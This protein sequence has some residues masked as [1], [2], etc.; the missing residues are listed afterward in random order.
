MSEDQRVWAWRHPRPEGAAGRCIGAGTDLPVHWRRA[1]RLARRIQATARRERLPHCIHS[2]PLRRCR[3]VG[4]WLRRWGWTHRVDAAL[5]ELDFG[6]WEGQ[7]WQAIGQAEVD[8]WC[9]DFG[10]YAPGGGEALNALLARA[11]AWSAQ[12]PALVVS[13]GGWMLARRW[14]SEGKPP[15]ASAADWPAAPRYGELWRLV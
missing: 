6:R 3:E 11:G 10:A 9:A 14:V 4:A 7:P 13:H 5:L 2:S 12:T 1:K 15:P 8:A